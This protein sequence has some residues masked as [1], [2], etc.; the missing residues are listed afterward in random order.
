MGITQTTKEGFLFI[1]LDILMGWSD[2]SSIRERCCIGRLFEKSFPFNNTSVLARAP[3][4][5]TLFYKW[6]KCQLSPFS[7]R[8]PYFCMVL[9]QRQ[10]SPNIKI[11]F[12]ALSCPWVYWIKRFFL[13][14]S[15]FGTKL[16]S[17]VKVRDWQFCHQYHG[18]DINIHKV[19]LSKLL[20]L[21]C[22][23]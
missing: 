22:V 15:P 20:C 19:L 23:R 21:L 12:L 16:L 13:S 17:L 14:V 9:I 5:N 11:V 3:S 2:S 6:G 7:T 4:D 18:Y 8:I 1:K 10:A